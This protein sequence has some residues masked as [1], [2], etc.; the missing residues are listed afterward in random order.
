MTRRINVDGL[1]VPLAWA[2]S[3]SVLAGGLVLAVLAF[4][5]PSGAPLHWALLG[6]VP[7]LVVACVLSG[8]EQ[9]PRAGSPGAGSGP[10]RAAAA[11]VACLALSVAVREGLPP[12]DEGQEL[13]AADVLVDPGGSSSL[14]FLAAVALLLG[15]VALMVSG[16]PE[17]SRPPSARP[18]RASL[19][20]S[21]APAVALTVLAVPTALD[22]DRLAHTLAPSLTD[23]GEAVPGEEVAWVWEHPEDGSAGGVDVVATATGALVLGDTGVWAL[24][25][26]DGTERWRFRPV[27]EVVWSGLSPDT[28]RVAVLYRDDS[29]TDRG[30]ALTILETDT[31]GL[32]GHHGVPDPVERVSLTNATFVQTGEGGTFTLRDHE[33]GEELSYAGTPDGCVPVGAPVVAGTRI[34]VPDT[35]EEA[36][37]HRGENPVRVLGARGDWFERA[38]LPGPVEELVSAPDGW[39]VVARHGGDEPGALALR[40]RDGGV[41]SSDLSEDDVVRVDPVNGE[42]LLFTEASEG[43]RRVEYRLE[44]PVVVPPGEGDPT[45]E[46]VAPLA[47]EF[48]DEL[49]VEEAE[50]A[51]DPG[52]VAAGPDLFAAVHGVPRATVGGGD[53]ALHL[54]VGAWGSEGTAVRLDTAAEGL[55]PAGSGFGV[56]LAPGAVVVS[57]LAVGERAHVVGVGPGPRG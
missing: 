21:L 50:L 3:G 38:E 49:S 47:F 4:T 55:A 22:R 57:G 37:R 53:P 9:R 16:R 54:L 7:L 1:W 20:A 35:C 2:G 15:A 25:T 13:P 40:G 41:I 19:L 12:R 33:S 36:G 31:G 27:G 5:V 52:S 44:R 56:A 14:F 11:L 51:L 32:V 28:E 42:R 17:L 48:A 34:L 46:P 43:A 29:E 39:A 24:D 30:R 26:R 23:A 18:R 6:A 8:G 10:V 45:I